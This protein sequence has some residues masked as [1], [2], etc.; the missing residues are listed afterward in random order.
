MNKDRSIGET[1]SRTLVAL[2]ATAGPYLGKDSNKPSQLPDRQPQ[3][4]FLQENE[5][6]SS[7][8]RIDLAVDMLPTNTPDI[9]NNPQVKAS[10]QRIS[11]E[12][13]S[14][15]QLTNPNGYE[16]EYV[17]NVVSARLEEGIAVTY[18]IQKDS[19]V[20]LKDAFTGVYIPVNTEILPADVFVINENGFDRLISAVRLPNGEVAEMIHDETGEIVGFH[21]LDEALLLQTDKQLVA[22]VSDAVNIT[23]YT[24]NIRAEASTQGNIL[25][26]LPPHSPLLVTGPKETNS[27]GEEWLP[28]DVDG[29][30]GWVRSDMIAPQRSENPQSPSLQVTPE[31][32]EI[33]L[34]MFNSASENVN[35]GN[36]AVEVQSMDNQSSSAPLENYAD[37]NHPEHETYEARYEE[38]PDSL[39]ERVNLPPGDTNRIAYSPSRTGFV[40]NNGLV[41]RTGMSPGNSNVEMGWMQEQ[42]SYQ[43]T[44]SSGILTTLIIESDPNYFARNGMPAQPQFTQMFRS[45]FPQF[46]EGWAQRILGNTIRVQFFDQLVL[47]GSNGGVSYVQPDAIGLIDG[48]R[49]TLSATGVTRLRGNEWSLRVYAIP[50]YF[51][52]GKNMTS[53]MASSA[54]M[55]SLRFLS[56]RIGGIN[57]NPSAVYQ[58]ASGYNSI[59]TVLPTASGLND[60][61]NPDSYGSIFE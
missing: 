47:S 60:A 37:I 2:A 3:V 5:P 52:S 40:D 61:Y 23:N 25:G 34:A 55:Y 46:V 9:I 50:T 57:I 35:G 54:M 43:W 21:P 27:Q 44:S 48:R 45:N 29:V 12:L 31:A 17:I 30:I 38:L 20:Y 4:I 7:T 42:I 28:V 49:T 18:V 53:Y 6:V 19:T 14:L 10:L 51:L 8:E 33:V 1:F 26:T 15:R 58:T 56:A 22:Q 41:W 16:S 32:G 11:G 59:I 39:K 13:S 36:E 24:V